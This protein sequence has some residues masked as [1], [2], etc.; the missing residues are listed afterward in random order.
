[1]KDFFGRNMLFLSGAHGLYDEKKT[2]LLCPHAT[3]TMA[4]CSRGGEGRCSVKSSATVESAV[5]GSEISWW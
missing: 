5:C 1:M 4:C 3:A 2:C